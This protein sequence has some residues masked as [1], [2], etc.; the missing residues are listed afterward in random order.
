MSESNKVVFI[1]YAREDTDAARRIAEALRSFG[2]E[3]WFDQNELRGGEAWDAKLRTQIRTCTL[4]MPVIS[5]TTQ[6]RSEGYFRREWKLAVERTHDMAAGKPFI[7]PVVIDATAEARAIVP[8]EFMRVQ[9]TRLP[10]GLPSAQ[11]IDQVKRLFQAPSP[12]PQDHVAPASR[13]S[14]QPGAKPTRWILPGAI[15][16]LGVAVLALIF[17]PRNGPPANSAAAPSAEPTKTLSRLDRSRLGVLPFT[18]IGSTADE[19]FAAGLSIEL[20]DRLWKIG[21]LQPIDG[22]AFMKNLG[23]GKDLPD[24]GRELKVGSVLQGSVQKANEAL[25]IRLQL[26]DVQSREILWSDSFNREFREIYAIYSEVAH[27]VAGKLKIAI[28]ST[29]KQQIAKAASNSPQAYNSFVKGRAIIYQWTP[30]AVR[31]GTDLLEEAVRIDPDFALAHAV[32]TEAYIIA[33]YIGQVPNAFQKAE[34]Q[35]Q[36]ALET[37][38]SLA[39][40]HYAMGLAKF[41]QWDFGATKRELELALQ[42]NDRFAMAHDWYGWYWVAMGDVDKGIAEMRRALELDP[43]SIVINPDLGYFYISARRY[44][45]AIQQARETL[46]LDP[47]NVQG[48]DVLN[49]ASVFLGDFDEVIKRLEARLRID[50]SSESDIATLGWAH[51]RSGNR[52]AALRRAAELEPFARASGRTDSLAIIYANVGERSRAFAELRTALENKSP[53]LLWLKLNPTW[54]PIRDDPQFTE[55]VKKVGLGR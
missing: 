9:W 17:W 30:Q 21:G 12:L 34:Q 33:G 5:A 28:L 13:T 41:H 6:A 39:E 7:V 24:I 44:R 46:K 11:F 2:V 51:A 19:G 4:F 36:R 35:A 18:T 37:D 29:E 31:T 27:V 10:G 3:V 47:A 55:L 48:L 1:S 25:L 53:G 15:G 42:I 54:D 14:S 22:A 45:E 16:I 8:E 52:A 43:L 50:P 20:L 40:S 38:D 49:T 32:L 23:A 26:V